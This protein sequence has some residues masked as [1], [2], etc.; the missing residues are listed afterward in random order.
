MMESS[1]RRVAKDAA[2]SCI[3]IG[4]DVPDQ[5]VVRIGFNLFEALLTALATLGPARALFETR[6][7]LPAKRG[8]GGLSCCHINRCGH[9]RFRAG[10]D[11][12]AA[13]QEVSAH[14]RKDAE[15]YGSGQY[16]YYCD[17]E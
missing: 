16:G 1:E 11:P 14:D 5:A 2:L 8:H 12:F 3:P 7:R 4:Y 6:F 15:Q 9:E 13:I 17:S 10:Y